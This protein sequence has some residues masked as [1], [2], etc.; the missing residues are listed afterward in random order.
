MSEPCRSVVA[1]RRKRFADG[2]TCISGITRSAAVA[3]S[4]RSGISERRGPRR[5]ARSSPR[6]S[7]R[8]SSASPRR[9]GGSG[10]RSSRGPCPR[11]AKPLSPAEAIGI[12]IMQVQVRLFATYR[13]V[14]GAGQLAW[15]LRDGTT[16]GQLVEAVLAKYQ[17]L[18]ERAKAKF[19]V[20][21]MSIVHRVGRVPVG[22]DSVVLACAAAHRSEAFAACSWA[23]DE[24][25]HIV[26]IWKTEAGP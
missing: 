12:R 4:R 25:K 13:E 21:E 10:P 22:G 2:H 17:E 23:M 1:C 8:T 20:L 14:V 19:G 26:P 3:G 18:V 15:T 11:D 5:P 7:T 9:S 6:H 16:V 24:V